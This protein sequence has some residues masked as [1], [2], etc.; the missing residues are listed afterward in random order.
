MQR[1]RFGWNTAEGT[2]LVVDDDESWYFKVK[3]IMRRS[4]FGQQIISA[5]NGLPALQ[6]CGPSL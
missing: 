3:R 2:I 6:N 5:H 1:G 4:G